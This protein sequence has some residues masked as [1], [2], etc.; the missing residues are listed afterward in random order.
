MLQK[1]FFNYLKLV[2]QMK[3]SNLSKQ[4]L[5]K[6]Q[7]KAGKYS[8]LFRNNTGMAFTGEQDY[9]KGQKILT[10]LKPIFFGI[11]L[12]IKKGKARQRPRGGG[13]YVGWTSKTVCEVIPPVLVSSVKNCC[14]KNC[15]T[16]RIAIFTNIEF[17][18]KNVN[19]TEEQIKFRE[20]V[21]EAGG[22]SEVVKEG[23]G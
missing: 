14:D 10:K 6:W 17:K 15:D 23:E 4:W 5:P 18:T 22:I 20:M 9:F 21:L 8:K 7:E 16:C 19:E 13:D 11:G 3:E 2:Y 12:L 1:V